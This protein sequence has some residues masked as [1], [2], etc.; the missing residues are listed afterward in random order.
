MYKFL[1]GTAAAVALS[2]AAQAVTVQV[3]T[4]QPTSVSQN[5]TIAQAAGLGAPDLTATVGGINFTDAPSFNSDTTTVG[6]FLGNPALSSATLDNAYF[7]FTGQIFLNAG[8]NL[9]TITHDDGLQLSIDGG[10]GMVVNQPGPTSPVATNFTATAPATGTYN[11]T[12]SYGECCGGPAELSWLFNGAPVG[13]V[14]EP[15]TWAMM[16]IGFAGIGIAIR[17]SKPAITQVA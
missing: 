15:S 12:L 8:A 6:E 14:P 9:F 17:R 11:F 7:L 5:A 13:G 3:W 16:L 1:L 10:V 4:N 2:S